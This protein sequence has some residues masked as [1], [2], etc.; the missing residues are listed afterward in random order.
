M[1]RIEIKSN[2]NWR[3]K[4]MK[5]CLLMLIMIFSLFGIESFSKE[6]NGVFPCVSTRFDAEKI[7]G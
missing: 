4:T 5:R 7:F 2:N 1:G 6:W 3:T